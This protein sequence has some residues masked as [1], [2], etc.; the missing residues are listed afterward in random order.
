MKILPQNQNQKSILR[1]IFKLK[2]ILT[3]VLVIMLA[4]ALGA[5]NGGGTTPPPAPPANGDEEN[6]TVDA[7]ETFHIVAAH[8]HNEAL[9][10]HNFFV[11]FEEEITNLSNGRITMDIFPAGQ[12][13][14]DADVTTGVQAGDFTMMGA[15]INPHANFI[16]DLAVFDIQFIHTDLDQA[17]RVLNDPELLA[18]VRQLYEENGF[19]FLAF[20]DSSFRYITANFPI[21]T[22][23][24]LDGLTIRASANVFHV[25]NWQALNANPT[26]LPIGEVMLHFNKVLL[27]LKT[28]LSSTTDSLDSMSNKL[29][30]WKQITFIT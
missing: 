24:D 15:N 12:V 10:V 1:R 13:G 16:Q 9:S 20:T 6:G 26:P 18:H 19:H 17:R 27:T 29:T 2:K 28:I 23:Q 8:S 7:G 5:C 14:G 22:P 11:Y 30:S 4:F 25:A 21:R 3:I